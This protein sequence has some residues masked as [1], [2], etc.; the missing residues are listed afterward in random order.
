[1]ARLLLIIAAVFFSNSLALNTCD[2]A[3]KGA[4]TSQSD[5]G[6]RGEPVLQIITTALGPAYPKEGDILELRLY[7]DG[8]FQYDDFPDYDPPRST[9]RNVTIK[10]SEGRLNESDV[11]ELLQLCA[12]DDLME[13]K[14]E[15]QSSSQHFDTKWITSVQC[16][17]PK[18]TKTIKAV[19]IWDTQHDSSLSSQYPPSLI[20]LLEEAEKFKGIAIGRESFQWLA[21][22]KGT[23]IR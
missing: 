17:T 19:N 5:G 21:R 12:H 13:A 4:R 3:S 2:L 10:L 1:M 6:E 14:D 11:K 15:Y 9:S 7:G 22:P 20:Q 23:Q 18:G 16:K 8:T